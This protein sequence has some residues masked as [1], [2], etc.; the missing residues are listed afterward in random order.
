MQDQRGDDERDQE[1]DTAV[2][3]QAGAVHPDPAGQHRAEAQQGRQIEEVGAQHDAEA[4]GVVPTPQRDDG[5]RDFGR[6]GAQ[7]RQQPQESFREA[8]AGAELV[9]PADKQLCGAQHEG[10]A[11]HEEDHDEAGR[12]RAL[13]FDETLRTVPGSPVAGK[14]ERRVPTRLP[15]APCVAVMVSHG[16]PPAQAEA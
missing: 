4:D 1:P 16:C 12:Q 15:G 11:R 13:H 9:D 14:W 8:D 6:V 2:K 3:R 7:G 5:R 10:Q